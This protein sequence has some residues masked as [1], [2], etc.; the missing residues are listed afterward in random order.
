M[1]LASAPYYWL[2]CD[3][4]GISSTADQ[5]YTAWEDAEQAE[6]VAEASDWFSEGGNHL[7]DGCIPL[8]REDDES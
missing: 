2:I 5:E 4:C 1:S 7:C 8:D 6:D 3:I